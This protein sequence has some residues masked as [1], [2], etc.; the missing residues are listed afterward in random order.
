MVIK[1]PNGLDRTKNGILVDNFFTHGI[2]DVWSPDYFISMDKVYGAAAPPVSTALT[3]FFN[4]ENT[5]TKTGK[6]FTT[7]DFTEV[8]AIIQPYA[9]KSITVQPYQVA[10]YV[11][12]MTM[13]P[14]A[15][16]WTDQQKA[17]DLV[18]NVNGEN[19][20]IILGP[21]TGSAPTQGDN[22]CIRNTAQ[23]IKYVNSLGLGTFNAKLKNSGKA[24]QQFGLS[25]T[26]T[27][28]M[29]LANL[30][31]MAVCTKHDVHVWGTQRNSIL[32][33]WFGKSTR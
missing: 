16:F 8:P 3:K 14:P 11:G 25:L 2:G 15:D 27:D 28:R 1:D 23:F 5:N 10:K 31:N 13:D 26:L 4:A 30:A 20:N 24:F 21:P 18:V 19:D 33:S 29:R 7:L 17:P 12:V 9:T 22:S 32:S 6:K